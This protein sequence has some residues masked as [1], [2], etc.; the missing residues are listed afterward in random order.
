MV[1][2]DRLCANVPTGHH[3]RI[4]GRKRARLF[5]TRVCVNTSSE[6][7]DTWIGVA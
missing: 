7:R 5:N 3:I 4:Q 6:L 1:D 2:D